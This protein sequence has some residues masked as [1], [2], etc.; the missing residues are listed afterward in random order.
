M[1]SFNCS[2]VFNAGEPAVCLADS[3][4]SFFAVSFL[5]QTYIRAGQQ[6]F[7]SVLLPQK[8]FMIWL[9]FVLKYSSYIL[10]LFQMNT[11]PLKV[12]FKKNVLRVTFND[13]F[14]PF[15]TFWLWTVSSLSN[16]EFT[17]YTVT[18]TTTTK[19]MSDDLWQDTELPTMIN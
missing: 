7:S 10:H 18:T 14:F 11:H 3:S 2:S 8:L 6:G 13:L 9:I 4:F 16:I 15:I 19:R 1:L 17:E 12:T 5:S